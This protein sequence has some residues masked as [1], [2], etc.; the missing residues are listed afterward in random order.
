MSMPMNY[1]MDGYLLAT[2]RPKG[3]I[4]LHRFVRNGVVARGIFTSSPIRRILGDRIETENSIWRITIVPP[5]EPFQLETMP[6][7]QP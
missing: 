5:L 4:R 6:E 2:P 3:I 7:E 1:V